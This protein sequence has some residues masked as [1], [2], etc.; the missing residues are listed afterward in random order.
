MA[1]T[2][3]TSR[4]Q[5]HPGSAETRSG[6]TGI[7]A[8]RMIK[9]AKKVGN[10]LIETV[11]DQ[12][13]SLL[14]E[15]RSHAADQIASVADMVRNSVRSLDQEGG[16]AVRRYT[17]DTARAIDDFGE[18]LRDRPWG[19]LARD[20]EDFARRWPMAFMASAIAAGFI[21]GRFFVSSGERETASPPRSTPITS[22]SM[23]SEPRGGARYD[24]GAVDGTVLGNAKAGDGASG[25]KD[26]H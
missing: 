25:S 17:E 8:E 23:S 12:A 4:S 5:S 9:S 7:D 20:V 10:Q 14:D 1:D 13:V 6:D 3:F 11:R 22:A 24:Y 2:Q 19:E 26:S 21:A 18:T 16:G 15:Q